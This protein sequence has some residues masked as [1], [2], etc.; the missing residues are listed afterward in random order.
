MTTEEAIKTLQKLQAEYNDKYIDYEGANDAYKMAIHD[1]KTIEKLKKLI[2]MY[3]Q[4][5]HAPT[6][7]ISMEDLKEMIE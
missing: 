1:M 3:S 4:Q 7:T 5:G 6:R 2:N